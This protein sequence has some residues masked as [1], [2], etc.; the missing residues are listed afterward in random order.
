MHLHREGMMNLL[1]PFHPMMRLVEQLALARHAPDGE[2]AEGPHGEEQQRHDQESDKK[3]ALDRSAHAG[4]PADQGSHRT[5]EKKG[6][7]RICSIEPHWERGEYTP[8]A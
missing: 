1:R 3:L 2:H 6:C 5:A 4:D 8:S 7:E